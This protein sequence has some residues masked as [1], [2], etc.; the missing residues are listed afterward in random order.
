MMLFQFH[1]ISLF[2]FSVYSNVIISELFPNKYFDEFYSY[3]PF[4]I[5]ID[6]LMC[7][8]GYVIITI[9]S[10]PYVFINGQQGGGAGVLN[11]KQI[12]ELCKNIQTSYSSELERDEPYQTWKDYNFLH[13][14][15]FPSRLPSHSIQYQ[16]FIHF[17]PFSMI[18]KSKNLLLHY[19]I[20]K[21]YN[22]IIII[23]IWEKF[24]DINEHSSEI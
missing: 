8:H 12:L 17:Q 18:E 15:I 23:F 16:I 9:F 14:T 4:F 13:F 24:R 7:N 19:I 1:L 5:T 6:S 3:K 21:K 10:L 2:D 22:L 20:W 11:H